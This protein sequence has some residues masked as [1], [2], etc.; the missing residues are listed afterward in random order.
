METSNAKII[1]LKNFQKIYGNEEQLCIYVINNRITRYVV[2]KGDHVYPY[3]DYNC[4]Y[5]EFETQLSVDTLCKIAKVK[6]RFFRD[7][8]E[9]SENPRYMLRGL[10]I[11]LNE[12]NINISNKRILDFGCGAGA[13]SLNLLRLGALNICGVDVD[14]NLIDI[15]NS[16]LNDFYN[17]G[18]TIQQIN[19][20]NGFYQ[21]P[22]NDNT[23]DIVWAHAV[24]EHVVPNQRANVLKELQRVL[25]K[26]GLLIIDS[27]P[28]RMW[29]K[30]NHTSQ[31][32]FVN[33]LPLKI[34]GYLARHYSKRIP[35]NQSTEKLLER[36]FRGITYWEI[37]NYLPEIIWLNNEIRKK[38]LLV[39][40]KIWREDDDPFYKKSLKDLY[41]FLM[42]VIDP[43]L[44]FFHLP[45]TAFL[46]WHTIVLKKS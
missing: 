7:E 40:M 11:L 9:R 2:I 34:A 28:N 22:F 37:K 5:S 46:P 8:I 1:N 4:N 12:Y 16:R 35:R 45:Q 14:T 39:F 18:Y 31:P 29:I 24:M 25:K 13:F 21:M 17:N 10:S 3:V 6:G 43:F 15:A 19:Y 36:G 23:F 30:E 41:W 44:S 27:T 42:I 32:Y 38:D 20:I 26:D 33:Y